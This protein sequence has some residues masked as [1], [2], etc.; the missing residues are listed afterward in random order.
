MF[1]PRAPR[2]LLARAAHQFVSASNVSQNHLFTRAETEW[3]ESYSV[4]TSNILFILSGAFVGL[5]DV[6]KKRM[7]KGVNAIYAGIH[8]KLAADAALHIVDR[9]HRQPRN[10]TLTLGHYCGYAFLHTQRQSADNPP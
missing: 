6:I 5:E 1:P 8:A 2:C 3:P 4:D 9:L 7:A 10:D